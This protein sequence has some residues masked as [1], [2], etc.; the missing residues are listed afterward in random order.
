MI[1]YA[2]I[3]HELL[4]YG[5]MRHINRNVIS[6]SLRNHGVID[7]VTHIVCIMQYESSNREAIFFSIDSV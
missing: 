2:S 7:K 5:D 4:F 1:S 3:N 6:R